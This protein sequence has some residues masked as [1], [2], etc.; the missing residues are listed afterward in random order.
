MWCSSTVR[1]LFVLERPYLCAVCFLW[2]KYWIFYCCARCTMSGGNESRVCAEGD[3]CLFRVRLIKSTVKIVMMIK[4][5]NNRR[6]GVDFGE[7]MDEGRRFN[8]RMATWW[9]CAA[10]PL[11]RSFY[12]FNCSIIKN[13]CF[14]FNAG[15]MGALLN[16]TTLKTMS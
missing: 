8:V 13:V 16:L 10:I 7:M 4:R 1:Y 9:R 2:S 3:W 6:H 14:R 11:I 12:H 5:R 15:D